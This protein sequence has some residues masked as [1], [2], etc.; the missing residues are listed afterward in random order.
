LF[1][2]AMNRIVGDHRG[3]GDTYESA[4]GCGSGQA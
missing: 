3:R 2:S 1:L 4:T